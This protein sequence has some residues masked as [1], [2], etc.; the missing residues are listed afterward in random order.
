MLELGAAL[1]KLFGLTALMRISGTIA[2][3]PRIKMDS[4]MRESDLN[5]ERIFF[6]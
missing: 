2:M 1:R 3:L 5:L 4:R 6:K